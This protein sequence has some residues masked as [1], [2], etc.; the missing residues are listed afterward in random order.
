VP[1]VSPRP[2]S[3]G[4]PKE[5]ID[6]LRELHQRAE[7]ADRDRHQAQQ[8]LYRAVAAAFDEGATHP[9]IARELGVD[10]TTVRDWKKRGLQLR[11]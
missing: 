6:K 3:P 8:A 9:Q 2:R 1:D 5:T 10:P 7:Q 11:G 4:A